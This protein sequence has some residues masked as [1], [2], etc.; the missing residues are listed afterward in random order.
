MQPKLSQH[1]G[2]YALTVNQHNEREAE[3]LIYGDIGE[4]WDEASTSA[5]D[6]VNALSALDVDNINVR[7]NSYGG[8][9]VD[10]LAIYNAMRRHPAQ[11]HVSIDGAA[12][13][14]GSYIPMAGDLVT[15]AENAIMMIHAPWSW[16]IGNAAKM[17]EEAD[18]LEKFANAMVSGYAQKS[19]MSEDDV[20][21]MLTDGQD[22]YLTA[23]E[24]LDMGLIDEITEPLQMAASLDISAQRFA[25][26]PVA[27]AAFFK[28]PEQEG[29][30]MPNKA[31]QAADPKPHTEIDEEA[32]TLKA[33]QDA[34]A[35]DKQ[36][37][38]S[39]RNI[40]KPFM[41]QAGVAE[42][43][44]ECQD[45]I[46]CQKHIAQAKLLD[47]LG[48]GTQPV[49]GAVVMQDSRDKFKSGVAAAL[50]YKA[51]VSKT[52]DSGNEFLGHSLVEIAR[53]SLA[54]ANISTGGMSKMELVGAA[55]GAHSTSDFTSLLADVANKSMQMGYEEAEETFQ[56]WT[57]RGILTDFKPTKRVD[58][59]SFPS[60][61]KV[62]EGAEY[63][64][65][66]VGDRGETVT[67]ATYG[68]LFSITRQAIINDDLGAFTR[69]P[70]K[71]GRAA[72]R[73]VGDLVYAI[74][75]GNPT[76]SD[77]TALFDAA[78]NNVGTGGVISTAS[79]DEMRTLLA[80]QTDASSNAHA[81][82][83]RLAN[84]LVPVALEGTARVVRDSQYEVGATTTTKNNTVPNSVRETFEVISD[85]R[86]DADS[87][88]KWYGSA[89]PGMHDTIEVSYL[90][91][92]DMPYM[93]Q[94]NG[95]TVDGA[96]FKVRIDAA[97]APLD[98][99]TMAYN[100]GA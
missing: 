72:I 1:F 69:I 90:D 97:A 63:T 10:G 78:H 75:T 99:R 34:L 85:A 46:E 100:A 20:R 92:N 9:V 11:V 29:H 18:T 79:V 52:R 27:A 57:N 8:A 39:I 7:V 26:L 67:L 83:I 35:A 24:A 98:F 12:M 15:M 22:H 21:A 41:S 25:R 89:A 48:N 54:Q 66:T 82:N 65:G 19:G 73:T 5:V 68:K 77:G 49:G 45:D 94:Q 91:G 2:P 14:M 13:S 58:L 4:T 61:S 32:L 31:T 51:G 50:A 60:L 53:A 86:L 87:S 6:F 30:T 47:H 74:L 3:V 93:E 59:N 95:W 44:Q 33:R 23:G 40:Y 36:R 81:L 16:V 80:T 38:D 37:R 88:V 56:I 84:L 55:F 96:D 28:T 70:M 17:R 76:M 64:Y 62:N 71:M 42:L 43:M